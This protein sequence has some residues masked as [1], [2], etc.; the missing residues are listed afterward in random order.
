[1]NCATCFLDAQ[2]RWGRLRAIPCLAAALLLSSVTMAAAQQQAQETTAIVS[3]QVVHAASGEP[4]PD[5]QIV[6]LGTARRVVSGPSGGFR[7]GQLRPGT[8]LIQA[9]ALG[10]RS[11]TQPVEL[12]AGGAKELNLRLAASALPLDELVV[13]GQPSAV[14]RREI[15]A[16]IAT[17]DADALAPALINT[18]SQLLQA[19]APGVTVLPGGGKPGQGSRIVLRGVSSLTQDIQP[20]IYVDGVRIDNSAVSGIDVGG[21]S[22]AGIDDINP[23][24]IER[25]EI[26]RGPSAAALYGTEASGG[27]I[28][29]FTKQGR[30]GKQQFSFRSEYGVSDTPRDWWEVSPQG[31]WFYD[32]VVRRGAQHRQYLSVRGAVERFSYYAAGTFHENE[33]VLPNSSLDHRT[34]RSNMRV[35]PAQNFGIG[36]TTAFSQREIEF[37]S[38]GELGWGLVRNALVGGAGG[39]PTLERDSLSPGQITELESVLSSTRFTAGVT[40]DFIPFPNFAHRLTVGGDV[41]NSDNTEWHPFGS[42]IFVEGTKAN[43]RR[44]AR[45]LNLDYAGG[46]TFQVTP[47]VRSSTSFGFQTYARE[48][49]TNFAAGERFVGPGLFTV[50]VTGLTRGD[51]D[52]RQTRHAGFYLQEQLGVNDRLFV[53]AGARL[54]GHSAFGPENRYQFYPRLGASYVLSEHDFL[55]AAINS[56]RLRAA[57]GAAGRQPEDFIA[58]RTWAPIPAVAQIGLTTGNLGN[59][60]LA[61][62]VTRELEAGFDAGV[63]NDRLALEFTYYRQRTTGALFPVQYAPSSGWIEPR[64]ENVGE[65]ENQGFEMTARAALLELPALRWNARASLSTNR[66]RVLETGGHEPLH[67]VG[68]QW[69]RAG[70]PVAGFFADRLQPGEAGDVLVQGDFIG[71]AFPTRS[72]Q[73]GSDV[74]FRSN[75]GLHV[76]FDHRGGHYLESNTLRGI[77]EAGDPVANPLRER[78]PFVHSADIWRLRE[79]AISYTVPGALTRRLP[80]TGATISLAGRNLWRQQEYPGLEAEASFDALRPLGSQTFFDTPLPRQVTVGIGVQF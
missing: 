79:A 68:A 67:A 57:Y 40:L 78:S 77:A 75:L 70:F 44:H 66:N 36:I 76:L 12:A 10:F 56:L 22:W 4:I 25:V 7:I 28:Q 23:D 34:F 41:F 46:Y 72:I 14:A 19:R 33:G 63:L 53:T 43:Y 49:S 80:V 9:R 69:I 42:A 1:M 45:T 27:V 3:G 2:R 73:L 39:I 58:A 74:T 29:I 6:V 59:P 48:I 47:A 37:P 13:T 15:G 24:D 54:D 17:I 62:E 5:A 61:P 52:R 16:S 64:F 38:D 60:D 31:A 35:I 51:E 55:P 71:P 20:I 8:Y 21:S 65:I 26:V 30:G 18:T 32:N 11:A 50:R